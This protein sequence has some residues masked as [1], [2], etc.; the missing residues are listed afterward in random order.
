MSIGA[1]GNAPTEDPI[2][3]GGLFRGIGALVATSWRESPGRMLLAAA[4]VAVQAIAI[5]FAAAALSALT[6]AA[7]AGDTRGA[8]TAA[9]VGAILLI[10]ALTAG[11]FAHIFHFELGEAA[12][13][14]VQ[15]RLILLSNGSAGLA[16]HDRADYADRLQVL[17]QEVGRTRE[18]VETLF[19]A[20]SLAI[21]MITTAVL[22]ALVSP[23]LLLLP[24]AAIPP[25]LLGRRAEDILATA[26]EAAAGDTRRSWHLLRLAT[27]AGSAKEL[28]ASGLATELR[29]RQG[30]AWTAAT[31]ILMRAQLRALAPWLVGQLIFSVAYVGATLLVVAQAVDGRASVGDVI[32]VIIL[33][34]QVNQQVAAAVGVLQ[35]LQ[36]GSRMMRTID[37]VEELVHRD[38]PAQ[39]EA[40]AVGCCT[41]ASA[42][43]T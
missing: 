25:L 10:A 6:D 23:W 24:L 13:L 3:Q 21:A 2:G 20:F 11:H 28:R 29:D 27:S 7:L 5:P 8:V 33:A 30:A 18:L 35:Q 40:G 32:L 37:W 4:L 17:R 36:R 34:G 15:R 22:L 9:V 1:T 12:E 14:A 39:P 31:R 19:N 42:S 38:D 26:R 41:R 16:H 43:T